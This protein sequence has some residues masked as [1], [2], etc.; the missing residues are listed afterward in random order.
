AFRTS[1][2]SEVGT[3]IAVAPAARA[4]SMPDTASSTTTH[5]R[6]GT[7]ILDA[8]SRNRSGAGL[9]RDTSAVVHTT[10]KSGA[11]PVSSSENATF[12]GLLEDA[13]ALGTHRRAIISGTP[14]KAHKTPRARS[15]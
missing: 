14:G 15:S 13:I 5:A 12:L 4:A 9:P 6:A 8:A 3:P 10:S 7:P 2:E 1:G 11:R